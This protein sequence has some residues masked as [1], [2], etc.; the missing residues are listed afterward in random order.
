M[1]ETSEAT[2]TTTTPIEVTKSFVVHQCK[3]KQTEQGRWVCELFE[4]MWGE[5]GCMCEDKPM[6]DFS[7]CPS[8]AILN[9]QDSRCTGFSV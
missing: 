3:L 4:D 9:M 7:I 5:Q 6:T 8:N 1:S 2:T